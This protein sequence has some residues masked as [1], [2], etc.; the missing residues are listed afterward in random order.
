MP[1]PAALREPNKQMGP[2]ARGSLPV[3]AAARIPALGI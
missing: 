1:M 3:Q 2:P